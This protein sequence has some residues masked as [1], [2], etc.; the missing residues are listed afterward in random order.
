MQVTEFFHQDDKEATCK[1]FRKITVFLFFQIAY[2]HCS[3]SERPRKAALLYSTVALGVVAVIQ[4]S[5]Y[6][7][8]SFYAKT[9]NW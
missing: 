3:L 9:T 7:F 6:I 4:F 2:T 8:L 1:S 5:A